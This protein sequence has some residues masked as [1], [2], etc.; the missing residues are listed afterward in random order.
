MSITCGPRG[1]G[2]DG[3]PGH[4][5]VLAKDDDTGQAG[6]YVV[7]QDRERLGTAFS[8]EKAKALAERHAAE[9]RL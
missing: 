4:Y 5:F 1:D 2:H 7:F 8:L 6:Y 9:G 3:M